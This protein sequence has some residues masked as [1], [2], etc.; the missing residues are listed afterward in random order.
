MASSLVQIW[1][2]WRAR[3][4]VRHPY[5]VGD[6]QHMC[7]PSPLADRPLQIVSSVAR[8]LY[9]RWW[10]RVVA[11]HLY[12]IGDGP[13]ICGP[14]SI[15]DRWWALRLHLHFQNAILG[16]TCTSRLALA[17]AIYYIKIQITINVHYTRNILHQ[18]SRFGPHFNSKWTSN[19]GYQISDNN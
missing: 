5:H 17:L 16:Y 14:S 2:R 3:F 9:L 19:L 1:L 18:D 7:N 4:V 13:H 12:L 10:A 8:H 11:R 15:F 6:W